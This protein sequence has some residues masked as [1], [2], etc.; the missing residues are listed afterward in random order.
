MKLIK[1]SCRQCRRGLR[2]TNESKRVTLK[3]R[4]ARRKAKQE[5]KRGNEPET[6]VRVGYTD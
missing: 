3:V 4:A 2:S 6:R 5:L 1:C